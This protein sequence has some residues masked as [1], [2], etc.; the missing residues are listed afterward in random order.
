MA[1]AGILAA[2]RII[3][4]KMKEQTFLFLGAGSAGTGIA[5]LISLAMTEEGLSRGRRHAR[6][7]GSWMSTA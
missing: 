6:A 4:G 7:A 5:E 3:N 2:L 1:V